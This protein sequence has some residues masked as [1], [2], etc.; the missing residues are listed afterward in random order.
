MTDVLPCSKPG[1]IRS[2]IEPGPAQLGQPHG[3]VRR[4]LYKLNQAIWSRPAMAI[5]SETA[6]AKMRVTHSRG[7]QE[8]GGDKMGTLRTV[9]ATKLPS[10]ILKPSTTYTN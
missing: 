9:P 8:E 6:T 3:L 4:V 5:I 1:L 7:R 10:K 2:L